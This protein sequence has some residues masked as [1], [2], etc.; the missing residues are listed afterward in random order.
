M[1]EEV[2]EM[3]DIY[4]EVIKNL[5]QLYQNIGIAE[6]PIELYETFRY[7]YLNGY[8]SCDKYSEIIPDSLIELE[9][10]IPMDIVGMMVM[11]NYG[12]CRHT[13]DFLVHIYEYL[14]YISSQ[15]FLYL[16]K[17]K[18]YNKKNSELWN[19]YIQQCIDDTMQKLDLFGKEK[20]QIVKKYNNVRIAI[21]YS[22]C[23]FRINHTVNI[24]KKKQENRV[25]ILD[26]RKHAIGDIID[27]KQI[28]LKSLDSGF[29][30]TAFV[31]SFIFNTYY[32]TDYEKGLRLLNTYDTQTA[33]DFLDAILYQQ[34]LEKFEDEYK[35]FKLNNQKKFALVA[36]NFQKMI[37]RKF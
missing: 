33:I 6:R 34:K 10:Y 9:Q 7:M 8:L 31:E 28:I 21:D 14:D 26:T 4:E 24:V 36:D 15:L 12:V 5:C 13:T 32:H 35:E 37:K 2:K 11:A 27:E 29:S 17:I 25:Y 22:P 23:K 18:I 20:A 19:D 3:V 16:P 30:S 1:L